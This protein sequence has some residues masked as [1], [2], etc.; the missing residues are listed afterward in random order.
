M[1]FAPIRKLLT[2]PEQLVDSLRRAI[3]SGELAEG[4]ALP[5]EKRL[6]EQFATNR[7]S[8]RQALQILKADGLIEG[9]QGK[10]WR[11]ADFRRVG[12]LHLLPELFLAQGFSEEVLE[13]IE[14]FMEIREPILLHVIRRA[15][16][17]RT[18][19]QARAM[20]EA[21]SRLEGLLEKDAPMEAVFCADLAWFEALIDA[22]GSLLLR[23]FYRPMSEIYK[24]S[25]SY[26]AQIWSPIACE[27]GG[28]LLSYREVIVQLQAAVESGDAERGE[29]ILRAYL[30]ADQANLRDK[31][32]GMMG[33]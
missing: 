17:R 5:A 16:K 4:E 12:G 3:L 28:E 18:E 25:A 2:I 19:E 32:M 9:G 30:R 7:V 13:I 31:L 21:L 11:V 6:A 23:F 1:I 22:S 33:G 20:R 26:I 24:R 27:V 15:A 29:E 8:L 14:D 10:A